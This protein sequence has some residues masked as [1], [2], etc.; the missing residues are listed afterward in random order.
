VNYVSKWVKTIVVKKADSRIVVKFLKRN[1]FC[2]FGSLR[3]LISDEGTLFCNEQL[4]R[5]SKHYKER[6]RIVAPYH[7]YTNGHVEVFQKDLKQ[8]LVIKITSCRKD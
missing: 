4:I 8:I 5:V 1:I 3:V 6:H 2:R 7:S